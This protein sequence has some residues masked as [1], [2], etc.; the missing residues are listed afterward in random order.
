MEVRLQTCEYIKSHVSQF[1]AFLSN[2]FDSYLEKMRK[3]MK[4]GGDI[5]VIA[6]QN[7]FGVRL[8]IYSSSASDPV[9]AGGGRACG[10]AG[11]RACMP[12]GPA[13]RSAAVA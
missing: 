2:D 1:M 3:P 13:G 7:L 6:M 10:R 8:V 12:G 5:E 11:V 9:R 4:W